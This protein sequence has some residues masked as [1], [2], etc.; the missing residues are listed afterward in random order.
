M[1]IKTLGYLAIGTI[2]VTL[3]VA[4]TVLYAKWQ[5]AELD[6]QN[7]LAAADTTRVVLEDSV[8][9]VTERLSFQER[10]KFD[11]EGSNS[12]LQ[13]RLA[14]L[15]DDNDELAAVLIRARIVIDS[16]HNIETRG[17]VVALDTTDTVRRLEATLDTNGVLVGIVADVPQPPKPAS[18]L[19]S[20]A[21]D[22]LNVVQ[23]ITR[24]PEG[25]LVW[26][27]AIGARARVMADS[28]VT[29]RT[30]RSGWRV[31]LP[32]HWALT[33]LMGAFTAGLG[34]GGIL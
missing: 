11:L 16:L 23:T 30:Q 12:V 27:G 29:T 13:N 22:P 4:T 3:G 20:F 33:L 10:E 26:R 8:A 14:A 18:V 31:S 34:V 9:T 1:K 19:W 25:A 7:A 15:A 6:K 28:I 21:M 17:T 32:G 2:V 24:T 5:D